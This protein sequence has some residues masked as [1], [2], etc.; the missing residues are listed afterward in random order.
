MFFAQRDGII[1]NIRTLVSSVYTGVKYH[2]RGAR[3]IRIEVHDNLDDGVR[4]T[5]V[6]IRPVS[7]NPSVIDPLK[8]ANRLTKIQRLINARQLGNI[9]N[10]V[11]IV[12]PHIGAEKRWGS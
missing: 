12:D 3:P 9:P 7:G 1:R 5:D 8:H 11:I 6:N 4:I 2:T 10:N